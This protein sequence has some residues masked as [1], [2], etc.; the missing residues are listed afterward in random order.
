MQVN[1]GLLTVEPKASTA[2]RE[3]ATGY[4]SWYGPWTYRDRG[5]PWSFLDA[6]G[7]DVRRLVVVGATR[8]R[9][10]VAIAMLGSGCLTGD[11]TAPRELSVIAIGSAS[12]AAGQRV[13]NALVTI[14]ALWPARTGTR[15]G[16]TGQYPIAEWGIRTA[17]DGEFGIDLRVNPP[18]AQVCIVAYGTLP[19]DSVWRDTAAVLSNLKVVADGVVPDTARF[20]LTLLK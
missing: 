6:T 13:K 14:H 10:A 2:E 20:D 11:T 3:A 17:E 8:G 9:I 19:G 4:R 18:T 12:D 7:F 16:C 1:A 15:L 5:Y